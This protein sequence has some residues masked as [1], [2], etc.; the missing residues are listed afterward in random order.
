MTA[1]I[2]KTL[3]VPLTNEEQRLKGAELA[4]MQKRLEGIEAEKA[5]MSADFGGKIK[6][7]KRDLG[8]LAVVVRE[9]REFREVQ[10]S[11]HKDHG[12]GTVYMTREDTGEI[13]SSRPMRDDE[14]QIDLRDLQKQ[15][16]ALKDKGVTFTEG[17]RKAKGVGK[18]AEGTAS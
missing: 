8:D 14:R 12:T 6:T 1:P 5:A 3:P 13:I 17:K 18:P 4:G 9:K 16:K 2:W 7:L 11:E 15:A 10:C